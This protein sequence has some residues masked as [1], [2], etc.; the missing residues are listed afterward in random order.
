MFRDGRPGYLAAMATV[1]TTDTLRSLAEFRAESGCALSIYL[2]LDPSSTPTIPDVETKFNSLLAEAEKTAE[3]ISTR[4][5]RL[6]VRDDL[7]RI[8]TWW[9]GEFDRDG[10][11][12]VAIFAS[13]ADGLFRAL[14]LVDASGDS[15]HI[16]PTLYIA[17]LAGAIDRDGAIVAFVSRE[18]GTLYRLEGGRLREIADES[19]PQPGQHDQGGWSQARYQRHIDHLV[20]QHLKSVGGA[21][22]E[23]ARGAGLRIVVVG[24]E[25]MRRELEGAL[26]KD[27]RAAIVGWT[28]AEAHAG[29][30]ELLEAA[31]PLLDEARARADREALARFEEL[32]GRGERSAT[33]WKQVLDAASDAR[34]EVLLVGDAARTRGWECPQCG[35]ASADGGSCP[36][37]GEKLEERD[38]AVDLALHRTL[39]HGGRVVR[40]GTGALGGDA[41]GIAALLRF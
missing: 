20:H 34:V 28:T 40:V 15:V 25:E 38:D 19:E 7:S 39:A 3:T 14:P 13:S 12:G 9:D 30:S 29:P 22:A 5:C 2:D 4:D 27:A 37:D 17:P 32:H 33:G 11:R 16:A 8:R 35:R 36:L 26:S 10:A 6:A 21:L 1:V 24:P 23:H 18:R 31:R 41:R